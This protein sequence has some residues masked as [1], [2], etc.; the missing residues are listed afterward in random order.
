MTQTVAV[1]DYGSGNLH[2]VAKAVER[3]GQ[4]LRAA[5]LGDGAVARVGLKV[6]ALLAPL[7]FDVLL[8]VDVVLRAVDDGDVSQL[9]RHHLV[10]QDV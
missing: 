4:K 1:I 2:S 5:A 10:V 8:R 7:R 9:E 3:A 6:L